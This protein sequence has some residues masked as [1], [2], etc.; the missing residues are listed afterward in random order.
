MPRIALPFA[1]FVRSVRL[2]FRLFATADEDDDEDVLLD[3]VVVL[4]LFVELLNNC[5][6]A[7]T[8]AVVFGFVLTI[9]SV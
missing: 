6:V 2:E 9:K 5:L 3:V 8:A 7:L 1:K 4:L